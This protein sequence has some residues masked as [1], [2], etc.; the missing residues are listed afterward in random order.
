METSDG[1]WLNYG[2]FNGEPC[3][4]E[5]IVDWEQVI[6]TWYRVSDGVVLGS[7]ARLA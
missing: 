1:N 6:L 2:A 5:L 7:R 4:V 3:M